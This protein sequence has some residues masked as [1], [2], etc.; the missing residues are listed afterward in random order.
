MDPAP[1]KDDRPNVH[2]LPEV[3]ALV[4]GLAADLVGPQFKRTQRMQP[5]SYARVEY[6]LLARSG[7][8]PAPT[9]PQDIALLEDIERLLAT[10]TAVLHA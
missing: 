5:P 1:R 4:L 8:L 7:L 9:N 3:K 10:R 6:L 2:V